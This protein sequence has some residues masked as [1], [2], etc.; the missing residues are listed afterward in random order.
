MYQMIMVGFL[1]LPPTLRKLKNLFHSSYDIIAKNSVIFYEWV[2]IYSTC[3]YTCTC[4][5]A[6]TKECN[7]SEKNHF[8]IDKLY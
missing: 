5:F 3:T 6:E 4:T 2:N 8:E 1:W 7:K